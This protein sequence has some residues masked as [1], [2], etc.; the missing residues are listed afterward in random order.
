MGTRGR[1]TKGISRG[2]GGENTVMHKVIQ[3]L[4]SIISI[5]ETTS[6]NH[7]NRSFSA[8]LMIVL[9]CVDQVLQKLRE[10]H[11]LDVSPCV[12]VNPHRR[13]EMLFVPIVLVKNCVLVLL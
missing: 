11:L 12:N 6:G 2:T 4:P 9:H 7:G 10:I 13:Q 5:G 8:Q 3:K 1:N